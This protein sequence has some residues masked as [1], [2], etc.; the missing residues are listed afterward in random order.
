MLSRY[1]KDFEASPPI[2]RKVSNY[3][4]WHHVSFL[5]LPRR[6]P[7]PARALNRQA[8]RSRRWGDI[9]SVDDT[10]GFCFGGFSQ[11][12]WRCSVSYGDSG[13]SYSRRAHMFKHRIQGVILVSAFLPV[14][15]GMHGFGAST[16]WAMF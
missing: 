3:L 15:D 9:L 13:L 8:C 5:F 7:I 4:S 14:Y 12:S 11:Y 6:D 16:N 1:T 2:R 10:L